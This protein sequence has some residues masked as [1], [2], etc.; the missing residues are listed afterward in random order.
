MEQFI[1]YLS[2]LNPVHAAIAGYLAFTNTGSWIVVRFARMSPEP[3]PDFVKAIA[4]IS[5]GAC[6]EA[7]DAVFYEAMRELE[8]SATGGGEWQP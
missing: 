5:D 4:G 1:E 6:E 2:I 8:Y 7:L 3:R